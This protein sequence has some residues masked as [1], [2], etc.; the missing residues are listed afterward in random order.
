MWPIVVCQCILTSVEII[1]VHR[2]QALYPHRHYRSICYHRH[3]FPEHYLISHHPQAY[4]RI[5]V[6]MEPHAHHIFTDARWCYLLCSDD[7]IGDC[8]DGLSVNGWHC[9]RAI[10]GDGRFV[11]CGCRLIIN[12]QRLGQ[13]V[14]REELALGPSIELSTRIADSRFTSTINI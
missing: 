3:N 10:L 1:L 4:R 11:V 13:P 9:L 12:L 6:G 7:R 8:D 5:A 2:V 14:D